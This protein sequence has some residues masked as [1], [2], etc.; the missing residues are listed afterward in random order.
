MITR[1][2]IASRCSLF[3]HRL[4]GPDASGT[5]SPASRTACATADQTDAALCGGL[6]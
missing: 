3:H 4:A 5:S 1:E 2:V 6:G